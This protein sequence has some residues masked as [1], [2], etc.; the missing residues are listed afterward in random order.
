VYGGFLLLDTHFFDRYFIPLILFFLLLALAIVEPKQ[1]IFSKKQCWT[2]S[3]LT[4]VF[5]LFSMTATHD[6]LSWNRARWKAIHYLTEEKK[7][8]P[9]QIDGGYEFNGWHRRMKEKNEGNGKSWWWVESDDYVVSFGEL[10]G[11]GYE[12][13]KG[14]PFEQWA[15]VQTDSVYVLKR[16]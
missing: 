14:F 13:I 1:L 2:A 16:R 8:S 10:K 12:K 6:Y 3:L 7:L 15:P 11:L 4:G 5:A 9:Y